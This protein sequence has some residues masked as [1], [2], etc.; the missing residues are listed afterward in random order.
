MSL[1]QWEMYLEKG[2]VKT[3][4]VKGKQRDVIV[5]EDM[6][7]AQAYMEARRKENGNL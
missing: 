7:Q 3:K 6:E 4:N 5:F 2:D 1:D